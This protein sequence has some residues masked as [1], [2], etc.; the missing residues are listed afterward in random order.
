MT[1][2]TIDDPDSVTGVRSEPRHDD[3]PPP[4][5][6]KRVFV[7]PALIVVGLLAYGGFKHWETDRMAAQAQEEAIDFVPEVQT[8]TAKADPTDVTLTLPGE[9]QAF[10]VATIYPRATGYVA[11]RRVDIGSRVKAGDLLIHIAAPDLDQ[12]LAQAKA[13]L[14]QVQAS[15]GQ[16][17]AQLDQ[18]KANLALANVT[19]NRTNQ[20][21]AR[22]YETVQNNDNQRTQV[23]SQQAGVETAQAGIKVAEA[24]VKAQEATVDRLTALTAFEDVRAPFDGI[25]TTRGVDKGDLVNADTKTGSPLFTLAKDRI[26]RVTVHVPQSDAFAIRDGLSADVRLP[27]MPSRSFPGRIA[28]S[29]VALLNSARTLETEVDVD[30]PS[31][32]LRPGAFVNVSF[33]IPRDRPNV[34]LPAEALIFNQNGLQVATIQDDEVHL[35]KVTIYRDFGKTVELRDG[36]VGGEQVVLSPPSDLSDHAKVKVKERPEEQAK[37]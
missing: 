36:L 9:T 37:K 32:D 19:F 25:V 29:S 33:S 12:Q 34:V 11:E 21:T 8:I 22:G 24:N 3:G 28:R 31:G 5:P 23:Q 18:A 10:D 2:S 26:L 15:L 1:K 4:A 6:R 14:L 17:N 20:L 27:Q 30:N 13:Q 7:L 16:S 35:Q